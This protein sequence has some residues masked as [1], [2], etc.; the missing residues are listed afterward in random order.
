MKKYIF[1]IIP[2]MFVFWGLFNCDNPTDS[3]EPNPENVVV[4]TGQ[5]INFETSVPIANAVV[6][7]MDYTPEQ[8]TVTDVQGSFTFEFE[9]EQTTDVRVVAYKTTYVADTLSVL[10][11]PGQTIEDLQLKLTATSSTPVASGQAASIIL[12]GTSLP[13]IGVRESGLPE[14]TEITFEVQDSMGVPV[15]IEHS[16]MVDFEFGSSPGGDEFLHPLSA[17]TGPNGT[18]STSIFSGTI[19]GV[20]QIIASVTQGGEVIR[21][22]PVAMA[23]H[24]GLPDS[25]HFSIAVEKL[26]FPGFNIYGLID[27]I[28]AYVG[29]KYGNLVRPG[30]IV[31]F[32]TTGGI[33]EGSASTDE[34]GRANVD[35]MSADPRPNHPVLGWGHATVTARTADE[36]Q[37]TIET[38]GLV[39]FSGIP[40]ISVN[41]MSF[42]ISNGGS[43]PFFYTV[44]DQNG[45][46]LAEG[47]T[48]KVAV[49]KGDVEAM[50][51]TNLTLPDPQDPAWTNF[52][53]SLTDSK[54]DT[55]Q[56]NNVY[57]KISTTGPNGKKEFTIS[58]IAH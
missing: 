53:F 51:N 52:G 5:V 57:V 1:L 45:N 35:L 9:V 36:N 40:Q 23:I 16:V 24:G 25:V 12:S 3:D 46:P 19:A 4:L 27:V 31:Y 44:S 49:E 11:T 26:N 2:I 33:I 43:A 47:T 54:P 7:L 50:G 41:P 42:D 17:E 37:N 13:S 38:D 21:S 32:T 55:I 56:T 29:D 20:V 30:T 8:S 15:D 58:G 28:T 48:I 10:A 34:M 14:V 39:C 6:V 22:K 18:V